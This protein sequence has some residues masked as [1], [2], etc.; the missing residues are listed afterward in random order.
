MS[1]RRERGNC[2]RRSLSAV[3]FTVGLLAFG[4]IAVA[5]PLRLDYVVSDL[6]GG[7][8]RYDFTLTLDNNDSSWAPAQG[9]RWFVF[10][11]CGPS[12]TSPLT[13][14]TGVSVDPPWTGFGQTGGG[15]NGPDL[16]SVLTYFIPT[17][18]GET[19]SWSGTSSA[20]LH[21]GSLLWS[22]LLSQNGGILANLA[23]ANRLNELC[24]NG[25]LDAG[26]DC[27]DS[28]L[29]D[30]DCCSSTC[31]FEGSGSPCGDATDDECTN[32]DTCDGAGTCQ[33]NHEPAGVP[34][35]ADTDICT[36]DVCDGEGTCAHNETPA[37][38]C[39][40]S[41]LG[42]LKVFND[43]NPAKRQVLFS[44]TKGAS[45]IGD[46]GNPTTT[47]DY[48]LCVYDQ[49]GKVVAL[50]A[51]AATTCGTEPCW[52][53]TG[54][55]GNE[56][57]V[58]YKDTQDPAANDGVKLVK[59]K[60]DDGVAGRAKLKLSAK[61]QNIPVINMPAPLVAPVTAQVFTSDGSVC[62]GNAFQASDERKNDGQKYKAKFG[63]P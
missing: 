60:A 17:F 11:D 15:H 52:S 20:D 54:P 27:D 41:S 33:D 23:V 38:S 56:T 47:S 25:N 4:E 24:G 40:T 48:T 39:K 18:V 46:F 44:W 49:N 3:A 8:Y 57:G 5:T 36:R 26:E 12:C 42:L 6:G 51:P 61:G 58:R 19:R 55:S 50:T 7:V 14:F 53:F 59:G 29:V 9:F 22:N 37:G 28:N 16:Q 31:Q 2:W 32:P 43:S 30:G 45:P 10:G 35:T 21:Q 13:A 34:C 63:P 62:W 1:A